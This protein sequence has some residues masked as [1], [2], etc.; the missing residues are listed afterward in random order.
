MVLMVDGGGPARGRAFP[1]QGVSHVRECSLARDDALSVISAVRSRRL[2]TVVSDQALTVRFGWLPGRKTCRLRAEVLQA[3]ASSSRLLLQCD[4]R[5]W[6]F[7]WDGVHACTAKGSSGGLLSLR[8]GTR[9]LL[10]S[11]RSSALGEVRQRHQG[12]RL[13]TEGDGRRQPPCCPARIRVSIFPRWRRPA[14]V[15]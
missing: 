2:V 1:G 3:A 6:R 9:A 14:G 12:K 4:E 11:S 10:G 7:G 13:S 15:V 5:G 8:N